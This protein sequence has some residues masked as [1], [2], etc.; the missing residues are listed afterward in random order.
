MIKIEQNFTCYDTESLEQFL[1]WITERVVAFKKNDHRAQLET[2][3]IISV[4]DWEKPSGQDWERDLVKLNDSYKMRMKRIV[5]ASPKY[6]ASTPMGQLVEGLTHESVPA[7]MLHGLGERACEIE[8]IYNGHYDVNDS[9]HYQVRKVSSLVIDTHMAQRSGWGNIPV[10]PTVKMGQEHS[11]E[12]LKKG[13][14]I[15]K[16]EELKTREQTSLRA[17]DYELGRLR[18]AIEIVHGEFASLE[19]T[20]GKLAK[21]GQSADDPRFEQLIDVLEKLTRQLQLVAE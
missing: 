5:L 2:E 9:G 14:Q 11:R 13:Q 17:T 3:K 8:N 6:F 7:E 21:L 10:M 4:Y 16:I 1:N 18:K 20:R 15:K 19:R 12:D